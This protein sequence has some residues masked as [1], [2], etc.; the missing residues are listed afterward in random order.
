[1]LVVVAEGHTVAVAVAEVHTLVDV[2]VAEGHTLDAAAAA[3]AV[4][5]RSHRGPFDYHTFVEDT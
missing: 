2:A 4:A 1:M 3:V 5:D